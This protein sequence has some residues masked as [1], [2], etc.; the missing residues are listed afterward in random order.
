VQ[1]HYDPFTRR[2]SST[3]VHAANNSLYVRDEALVAQR[4][5][6]APPVDVYGIAV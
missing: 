5:Q 4:L 1:R 3:P 6:S 2:L